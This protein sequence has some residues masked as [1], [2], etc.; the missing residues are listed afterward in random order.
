MPAM[1]QR[2]I[3]SLWFPRLGAERAIRA[4]PFLA[5]RP[6]AIVEQ[7]GPAQVISSLSLA[8]S[9]A[10]LHPG[11]SLRDASALCAGLITRPRLI[12]RETAFLDA[13]HRWAGRFSPWVAAEPPASLV[14]D[15]TGCAHL[16]GGE[17]ALAGA[18]TQDCAD[19][20]LTVRL[21]L[22][23]TLGAAWALARYAGASAG[24]YRT[25]DA[26]EQEARATRSRAGKR[27]HWERGGAAPS[28]A[29]TPAVQGRIAPPGQSWQALSPLPVAALRLDADTQAQL[30]RLGLRRV[31]DLLGQPRAGLARRFGRGLV[32]RLDQ[33]TG[34]APEPISP[35]AAPER[36]AVRLSLPDPI[37]LRDDVEAALDRLLDHLCARLR[38]R[39][40]GARVLRL[41]AWRCDGTMSARNVTGAVASFD[42][43]R[44]KPL[45][46]MKLDDLEAGPGIDML[47]LE[48]PQTEP[49][50]DRTS[51]GHAEAAAR[52]TARS[53]QF[54]AF[55]DLIGRL[56]AR[57]GMDAITR[58]HPGQSHIPEKEALT[59]AAAWSD[60]CGDWPAPAVPRPLTLW[61]L[62]EPVQAPDHPDPPATFRWRGRDWT[63]AGATGPERIAPEWWLDDPAW[64]SGARDYWRVETDQGDRLWLFYAHG[65]ALSSGWFCH[66]AFA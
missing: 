3:L 43:D 28:A 24:A 40:R 16:F 58:R 50:H 21:G 39:A 65:A 42:A 38:A 34:A 9:A 49:I 30:A 46:A 32:D 11:Q 61:P 20:G 25:G 57:L 14:V 60:P 62:P 19:L 53:G 55:E 48:A 41:E 44:L 22:A 17:T 18:V 5:D 37:G 51:A 6:L 66:G 10:G 26:I 45:L 27:R 4:E 13:L 52:A 54:A 12:H 2:R 8:A 33:A 1:P 15:L 47:R 56:G 64:R 7:D 29:S 36:F 23:D 59:L 31:G 63:V 35:A